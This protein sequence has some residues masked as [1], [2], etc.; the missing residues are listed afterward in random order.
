MNIPT[1]IKQKAQQLGFDNC[2]YIGIRNGAQ[3]FLLDYSFTEK[4]AP[5]IGFPTIL[6]LHKNTISIITGP[7][8]LDLL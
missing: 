1:I 6:L 5:P 7:E 4:E 3:A 8:T 2:R